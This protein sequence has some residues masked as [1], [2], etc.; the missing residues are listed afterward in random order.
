VGRDG[1]SSHTDGFT[2]VGD[3]V[4]VAADDGTKGMELWTLGG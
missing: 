1:A 3:D 4:H 2:V